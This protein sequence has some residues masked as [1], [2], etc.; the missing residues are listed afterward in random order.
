MI[1]NMK[2]IDE[3]DSCRQEVGKGTDDAA[4]CQVPLAVIVAA[5]NQDARM[6]TLAFEE[7]LVEKL[8]ITV[9]VSKDYP[10]SL[11]GMTEVDRIVTS[12]SAHVPGQL[13]IVA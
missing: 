12:H 11:D 13:H 4:G 8:E 10:P 6:M 1:Q 5:D 7:Q 2:L 9:I 3:R